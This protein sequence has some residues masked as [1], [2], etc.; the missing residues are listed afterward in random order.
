[1]ACVVGLFVTRCSKSEQCQCYFLQVLGDAIPNV[2]K[3]R[4]WSKGYSENMLVLLAGPWFSH[5][6]NVTNSRSSV[7]PLCVSLF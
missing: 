5:N 7:I 2:K 1:M 6:Q 3:E 4:V